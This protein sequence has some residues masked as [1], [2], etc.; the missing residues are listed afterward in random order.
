MCDQVL[1]RNISKHFHT[2]RGLH[3][4]AGLRSQARNWDHPPP[5]LPAWLMLGSGAPFTSKQ[6]SKRTLPLPFPSGKSQGVCCLICCS[7]N[8]FRGPLPNSSQGGSLPLLLCFRVG[9]REM[10]LPFWLCVPKVFDT[11]ANQ[12][13]ACPPVFGS[14]G[15]SPHNCLGD[16]SPPLQH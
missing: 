3:V 16:L 6:L 15:K 2:V 1:I 8:N 12:P 7:V 10:C 11:V 4:M 9:M 14:E 5:F 13:P